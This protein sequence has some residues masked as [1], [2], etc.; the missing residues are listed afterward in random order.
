MF[1]G[2]DVILCA[3]L[4]YEIQDSSI[5]PDALPT[6]DSNNILMASFSGSPSFPV[7]THM[8][9]GA[10][11]QTSGAAQ[12]LLFWGGENVFMY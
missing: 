12:G 2:I 9:F 3:Y 7:G 1:F 11:H 6:M 4:A 10:V 8:T 5:E